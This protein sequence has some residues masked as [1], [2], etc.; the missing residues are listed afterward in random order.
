MNAH[1]TRWRGPILLLGLLAISGC[2]PSKAQQAKDAVRRGVAHAH[3]REF[4]QAIAEF[5][6][7]IRL[8]PNDAE[9]YYRRGAAYDE[10]YAAGLAI[11]DFTKAIQLDPN[12]AK[13][14]YYRYILYEETGEF[15][16]AKAD[17]AK[18]KLLGYEPQ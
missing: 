18:A 13:A 14:Y 10:V 1:G 4:Y 16:K 5:T 6:E 8:N 17:L 11:A 7:A 2:G 12:Y 3:Q 15:D 9:T